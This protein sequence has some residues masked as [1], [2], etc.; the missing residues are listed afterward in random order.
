MTVNIYN[1][2]KIKFT[3]ILN[4]KIYKMKKIVILI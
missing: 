4:L 1:T 2:T 3:T